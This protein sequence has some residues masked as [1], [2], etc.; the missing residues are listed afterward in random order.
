MSKFTNEK[1][2][3]IYPLELTNN[4]YIDLC[5][6][7]YNQLGYKVEPLKNILNFKSNSDGICLLNWIEDRIGYTKRGQWFELFRCLLILLWVKLKT[8]Q[9]IWVRHN[10][11]PHE[12]PIAS[13]PYN[14]LIKALYLLADDVVIHSEND[15]IKRTQ[16]VPH[17]LYIELNNVNLHQIKDID[18]LYFGVI[19]KYKALD[20]LLNEWPKDKRLVITG[21]CDDFNLECLLNSIIKN[22]NLDVIWI[23]EFLNTDVLNSYISRAK[24]VVLPHLDQA[25]IVSGAFYH[26]VSYGSNVIIRNGVFANQLIKKHSFVTVYCPG[27]LIDVLSNIKY[28][29]SDVVIKE[30]NTYYGVDSCKNAWGNIFK[31]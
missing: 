7:V 20:V 12:L 29:E 5:V 31:S 23:N 13:L 28:I 2:I 10:V 26:A 6:N 22:R 9:M 3:Y 17:P 15:K 8:K 30:S 16:I 27:K 25:M 18:Y 11:K 21:R 1:V 24:F 19:K 14:I 4:K